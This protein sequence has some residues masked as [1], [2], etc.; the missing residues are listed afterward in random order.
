MYEYEKY[1]KSA[2]CQ[3]FLFIICC[4]LLTIGYGA[5]YLALYIV[6]LFRGE[7]PSSKRRPGKRDK[8]ESFALIT[9]K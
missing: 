3:Q 4:I 9:R 5:I 1:Q 2:T 7:T 8:I 6:R